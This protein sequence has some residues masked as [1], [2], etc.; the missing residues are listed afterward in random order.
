MKS[1]ESRC[2]VWPA[3]M[4]CYRMTVAYDGTAYCGWQTQPGVSTVQGVL[5]AALLRIVGTAV[6]IIGSGRTDAGV[7]A[8]GQVASFR[9]STRLAPEVLCRAL[10]AN[11]PD[12]IYVREVREAADD[13]HAIRCA[14]SKRYRYII[15]D[16]TN[17]DLFQRAYAWYVPQPLDVDGMQAGALCLVGRHDFRSFEAAG[18]PRKTSVRTVSELTVRRVPRDAAESILIEIEADG[19]L[20]NMVRNIVGSLVLVG[21]GEQ[22][23]AWM[24]AVLG[25]QD[26]ACAGPTAPAG[27]LTL[28]GVRYGG[29][30]AG[31]QRH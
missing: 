13:F 14:V 3:A 16:G 7:H 6:R 17:R 26:R 23:A 25:A 15:Q 21:R 28:M 18:A 2:A 24:Q 1:E 12:D 5:E 30:G 31:E 9:C 8:W 27:G 22:P 4:Q 20:Y 11:T 19:F 29:A 10:N